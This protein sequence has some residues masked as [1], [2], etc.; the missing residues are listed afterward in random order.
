MCQICYYIINDINFASSNNK[1]WRQQHN[2]GRKKMKTYK[3]GTYKNGQQIANVVF[4]SEDLEEI[5]IEFER[6]FK[7][8]VE[9][10]WANILEDGYPE[11]TLF[12]TTFESAWYHKHFSEDVNNVA[13]FE[14]EEGQGCYT[15]Y[16]YTGMTSNQM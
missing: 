15:G 1:S 13:I 11:D 16:I 14:V 4:E 3:I 2:H 8:T 6:M 10:E 9:D 5:K 7:A 12:G